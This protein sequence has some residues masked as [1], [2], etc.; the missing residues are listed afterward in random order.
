MNKQQYERL[1]KFFL[2]QHRECA[3][4]QYELGLT[5]EQIPCK[6]LF[7]THFGYFRNLCPDNV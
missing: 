1:S 5:D 2:E 6:F 4:L 7:Q 3:K